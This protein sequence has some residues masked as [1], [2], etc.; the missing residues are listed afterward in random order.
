MKRLGAVTALTAMSAALCGCSSDNGGGD[1]TAMADVMR[2]AWDNRNASV[3]LAEAASIPYATMG[4]RIGDGAQQII[5]LATD[6]GGQR[7]W[8]SAARI[9]ITTSGGR[10]VSTAG[11]AANLTAVA[12]RDGL[13]APW[14]EPHRV[15]WTADLSDLGVY[16][17]SIVCQDTPAGHET[18]TILGKDFDTVRVD[19]TC[20]SDQLDWSFT[21]IYWVSLSSGTVWRSVQYIHPNMD[22]LELEILRP[23]VTPG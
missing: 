7:L 17:V 19:E 11:F 15:R 6:S 5:V 1:W 16:S 23:P 3:E 14:S 21:N 18:T 9:A 13:G 22:P 8:T 2:K 10:I 20:R 12:A 4:V